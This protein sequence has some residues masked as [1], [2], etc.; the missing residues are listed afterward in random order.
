[1]APEHVS[2]FFGKCR[3]KLFTGSI[4]R[5]VI[6]SQLV[7]A[8]VAALLFYP[9]ACIAADVEDPAH[10]ESRQ[11][12][13]VYE[14]EA[15]SVLAAPEDAYVPKKSSVGTKSETSI[16][17]TPQTVSVITRQQMEE[18]QPASPSAALRYTAGATSEKYGAFGEF[19]DMTRI[20]GV[21]ADYYL[22]GLRVI[23]NTGTWVPQIDPYMIE[24]VEVLRGP[25]SF[26]YGQGTGGGIVNQVSKMPQDTSA[27]E[28]RLQYGGYGRKQ[29]GIDSTGP[30]DDDGHWLYRL[31]ANG[32]DTN[33]QIDDTGHKRLSV[34]PSLTWRPTDDTSWTVSYLY[35]QEPELTNYST[36]PAVV[37]G[38]NNSPYPEIDAY[39]NYT[40]ASFEDSSRTL[41]SVSSF[42]KH[43]FNTAW[44]FSSNSRYM[45][46][47]SDLRR[48]SV[49]GYQVIDGLPWLRSYY[50]IAPAT[51]RAFSTDNFVQGVV[52]TGPLRHSLLAGIDYAVGTLTSKY[53]SSTPVLTNPYS[54]HYRP[55]VKPDFSASYAAPWKEYQDFTRMGV[56]LQDQIAY[57]Q[58]RL[59]LNGRHDWS[60]IDA[61]THSYSPVGRNTTQADSEWSWRT[62]IS[63]VFENGIAPYASYATAFSPVLGSGYDG[64]AF[65]PLKTRQYEFGIKYQPEDLNMLLTAAVF[66]LEQS[67]VK[68]ADAAHLGF[69]TQ[70]GEVR[71]QG[72]DLQASFALFGNFSVSAS[73]SYLYNVLT[74][75]TKYQD[76]TLAQTPEHS[77]AAWANY[78]FDEGP[79]EGLKVGGGVRYQGATWGNPENSFQVPATTLV[80]MAASYDLGA[81]SPAFEGATAALN[82]SNL[83]DEKYIASCSSANYCFPGQRRTVALTLTYRW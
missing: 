45:Y 46:A 26:I 21:D 32:L 60:K 75:D 9:V 83:T 15:V 61:T 58:W 36:L 72:V 5:V 22:D 8:V 54:S 73:Y 11:K 42:F 71:S 51:L 35:S 55:H 6:T 33:G 49:M 39:R 31:T 19:V 59:T 63:Y 13:K 78:F 27:H 52:D 3:K 2:I 34:M 57:G 66:N 17:E 20:R 47:E 74:K 53:Y 30:L 38:L 70:A 7:C 77:A 23:S 48:S 50:E 69:N 10:A 79:L 4:A 76:K 29:I 18:M 40:D 14:L 12:G 81:L 67:N 62:G 41:N 44:S 80:D 43:K 56:Y 28:I 25:S 16:L 64:S 37:L 68:T 24:N 82:I 1:M 65:K